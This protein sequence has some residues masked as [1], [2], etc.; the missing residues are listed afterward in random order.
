MFE[1]VI[2]GSDIITSKD[3]GRRFAAAD[4]KNALLRTVP[5]SMYKEVNYRNK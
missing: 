3:R 5:R 4:K 2:L 1:L